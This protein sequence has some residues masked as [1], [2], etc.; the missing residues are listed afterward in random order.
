MIVSLFEHKVIVLME[1][2][3]TR[4]FHF[5]DR[6]GGGKCRGE[7]PWKCSVR[8]RSGTR[9]VRTCGTSS[10][11]CPRLSCRRN[12]RRRRR[13]TTARCTCLNQWGHFR[14]LF[15]IAVFYR[16]GRF[17]SS[18]AKIRLIN[19]KAMASH[20]ELIY[21]IGS[22]DILTEIGKQKLARLLTTTH[23]RNGA[24]L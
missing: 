4:P 14:Y 19:T 1:T 7:L 2:S 16:Y 11:P 17:F 3:S 10:S 20:R 12:R 13:T 24:T 6:F 21:S 9:W 5:I 18:E 8:C 15:M 22:I 23:K